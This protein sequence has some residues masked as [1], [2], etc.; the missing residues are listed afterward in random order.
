[1]YVAFLVISHM[2]ALAAGFA[3]GKMSGFKD[4]QPQRDSKGRYIPRS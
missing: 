4:A 2:L 1:M 3:F